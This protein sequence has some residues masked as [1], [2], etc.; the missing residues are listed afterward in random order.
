MVAENT[1]GMD[2]DAAVKGGYS[3]AM[4]RAA[5]QFGIGR[6]LYALEEMFGEVN[7]GGRFRAKTKDEKRFRWNPPALPEWA[8]PPQRL[9]KQQ[10]H[11][12]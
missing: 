6:Y 7:A 1:K 8:L 11:G 5:V 9:T 3:A 12:R 10:E 2:G 4:K